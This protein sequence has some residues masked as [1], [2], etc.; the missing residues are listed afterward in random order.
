MYE[1]KLWRGATYTFGRYNGQAI[2]WRVLDVHEAAGSRRVLLLSEYCMEAMPYH[3]KREP[4]TW[5]ECSLQKWLNDHEDGFLKDFSD[6]DMAQIRETKVTTEKN[7][8]YGTSGGEEVDA[9]VFLLSI[10]EVTKY[11]PIDELR[12]STHR[13]ESTE[14]E[15]EKAWWWLRSPG[16]YQN[17]AAYVWHDGY[18]ID[19]GTYVCNTRGG[20]RPALYLN[21]GDELTE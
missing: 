11:L 19:Y 4:I 2:L 8:R 14:S 21:L 17:C 5:A 9:R 6:E 7:S 15:S 16:L 3:N 12:R 10:E 13:P 18:V 20:V 1:Q